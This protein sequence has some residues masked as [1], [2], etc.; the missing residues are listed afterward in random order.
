VAVDPIGTA[1]LLALW[2]ALALGRRRLGGFGAP[3]LFVVSSIT[4]LATAL[5]PAL[6]ASVVQ[7][8]AATILGA[9]ALYVSSSRDRLGAFRAGLTALVV[10]PQRRIWRALLVAVPL[11]L[12]LHGLAELKAEVP[13]PATFRAIHPAPPTSIDFREP[14]QDEPGPVGLV[15]A[16]NPLRAEAPDAFAAHMEAGRDLY[17][18]HCFFCHGADL[19]GGG[20]FADALAVRPTSFRDPSTI[21]ILEESYLFWRIAKGAA[22][23]PPE[24]TPE[25]SAMP[26][27]E[28]VL[29]SE[30]IWQVILFLYEQ[31]GQEP[32]AVA[33]HGEG[34]AS[35]K[36]DAA[37]NPEPAL[38]DAPE[39]W[40]SH[41]AW[42]HGAD[43]GGDAPY[44]DR[45]YP[46]PRAFR[47][48][49][50]YKRRSTGSGELALADDIRQ[51]IRDGLPGSAMPGWPRL[52]QPERSALT[53][54]LETTT[55]EFVDPLYQPGRVALAELATP[56]PPVTPE[57]LARGAD[58]YVEAD[59]RKCHGD[60]GRGDG[61]SWM[62]QVDDTG[63]PADPA[64]LTRPDRFRAGGTVEDVFRTI[65]TGLDGSAM[66]SFADTVSVEDR[67]ALAHHVLSLSEVA[68]PAALVVAPFAR[69]FDPT[70]GAAWTDVPSSLVALAPQLVRAPRLLWPSV[71]RVTVQAAHTGQDLHLRLR[72]HDREASTGADGNAR[73]PDFDTTVHRGRPHPDRVAVQFQPGRS[74]PSRLPPFLLGDAGRPV[75]VWTATA[76]APSPVEAIARGGAAIVDKPGSGTTG[77][78]TWID[79]RWTLQV[80][81][82]LTTDRARRD[83]QL[84]AGGYAP[85][86][87]SVWNGSRGEVGTRRSTSSWLSLYLAPPPSR[88]AA[89]APLGRALVALLLMLAIGA[90]VARWHDP[91]AP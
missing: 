40:T 67:Q 87:L 58:V 4:W 88:V 70:D 81:R 36:S 12:A 49:P 65:S 11:G 82:S 77:G 25:R 56:L 57:L 90:M 21:A 48:N 23:L 22:G 47:D 76:A 46:R 55:G 35:A 64:D 38:T 89:V 33:G 83:V 32:R 44:A 26:A 78:M 19:D 1:L 41:C 29:S 54:W 13:A 9:A 75:D 63:L 68:P 17:I 30:Q 2:V 73:Y 20:P 37:A 7:L 60:T 14:G 72:W 53:A 62:D 18:G 52:S 86:G 10:G 45:M 5:E 3:V 28:G 85:I 27:W 51:S 31:T 34:A 80:S 79:G 6:P 69:S 39:L 59:C 91:A 74:E 15:A 84:E 71:D 8:W 42:C 66:A 43:G 16:P 24:G 61:P 50:A